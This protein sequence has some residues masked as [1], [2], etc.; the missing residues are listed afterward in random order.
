MTQTATTRYRVHLPTKAILA[1]R[2]AI[3][4]PAHKFTDR[5]RLQRAFGASGKGLQEG[6]EM[7]RYINSFHDGTDAYGPE[8]FETDAKPTEHLGCLIYERI[9]GVGFDIVANG[10]CVHQRSSLNAAKTFINRIAVQLVEAQ[11][12]AG[13]YDHHMIDVLQKAGRK[14]CE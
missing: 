11:E 7:T 13:L 14:V 3:S 12:N 4:E 2:F 10:V 6:G 5:H 1:L 9:K 8:F